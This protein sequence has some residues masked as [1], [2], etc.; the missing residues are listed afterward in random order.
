M[1]RYIGI[2]GD[3]LLVDRTYPKWIGGLAVMGGV[4]ITVAGVVMAYTGFSGPAIAISMAAGSILLVWMLT[5]GVIMWR[6]GGVRTD[7][8]SACSIQRFSREAIIAEGAF[9]GKPVEVE[10]LTDT[11]KMRGTLFI[12]LGGDASRLSD[13][14][15]NSEKQFLAIT[16]AH[17]EALPDAE[18]K[19]ETR[20]LAVNKSVVTMLRAIEE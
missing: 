18:M 8:T 4:P 2:R 20:F 15:N 16:N 14:L 17:V 3:G 19:W 9:N 13:F 10:I 5:L 12:P 6:Q 11:Y 7:D 1:T